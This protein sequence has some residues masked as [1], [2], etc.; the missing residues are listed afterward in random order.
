MHPKDREQNV[1][2]KAA[3]GP[4]MLQIWEV[5]ISTSE[6]GGQVRRHRM[7]AAEDDPL[8]RLALGI[9]LNAGVVWDCKWQP[10]SGNKSR[11][12]LRSASPVSQDY[13]FKDPAPAGLW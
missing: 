11:C 6:R 4:G 7:R 10:G 1:M 5:D 9:C 13:R 8:A 2:G 12:E 3:A